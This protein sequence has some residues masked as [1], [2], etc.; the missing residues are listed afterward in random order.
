MGIVS[1]LYLGCIGF[2]IGILTILI[3]Q[4]PLIR[5]RKYGFGRKSSFDYTSTINSKIL[6]C[7]QDKQHANKE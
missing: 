5:R 2:V 4:V 7:D 6:Q 3:T 1:F